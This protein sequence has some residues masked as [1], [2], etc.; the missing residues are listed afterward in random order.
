M[1][2]YSE[3][4]GWGGACTELFSGWGGACTELFSGWGEV[5]TELFIGCEGHV[6][7]CLVVGRGMN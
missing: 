5:C 2:C 1:C 7:N 4:T 3:V 6:L